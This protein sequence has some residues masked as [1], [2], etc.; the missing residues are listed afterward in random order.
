MQRARIGIDRVASREQ[1]RI[2]KKRAVLDCRIDA[3]EILIDDPPG[4]DIHVSNFGIAH[5]TVRQTHELALGVDQRM[6]AIVKQTSPVRQIRLRDRVVGLIAAFTM[7]PAIE[8]Q[9]Q[10]GFGSMTFG[11]HGRLVGGAGLL[12]LLV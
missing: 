9:Q 8:N 11:T 10:H 1:F 5:L 7:T 12:W 4:A 2:V 3:R 6:R